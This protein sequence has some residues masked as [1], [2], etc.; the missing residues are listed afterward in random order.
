MMNIYP[1][2]FPKRYPRRVKKSSVFSS[3]EAFVFGIF[4]GYVLQMVLKAIFA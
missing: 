4:V 2:S 1:G 3:W